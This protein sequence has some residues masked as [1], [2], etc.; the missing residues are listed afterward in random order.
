MVLEP[1]TV[2]RIPNLLHL[3]ERPCFI[4]IQNNGSIISAFVSEDKL[5]RDS[6]LNYFQYFISCYQQNILRMG[7][8]K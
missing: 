1:L 8:L 4:H 2:F 3:C 7:I 5:V 6:K